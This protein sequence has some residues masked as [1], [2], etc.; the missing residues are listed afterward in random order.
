MNA[1]VKGTGLGARR[2][3]VSLSG[4]AKRRNENKECSCVSV[5]VYVCMRLCVRVCVKM[6][7]GGEC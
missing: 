7:R 5:L 2:T 3:H 4:I 1:N 6:R